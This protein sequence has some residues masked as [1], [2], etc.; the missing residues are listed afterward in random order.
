MK[1]LIIA[2]VMSLGTAAF[3]QEATGTPENP[4][5]S[6][7]SS[8]QMNGPST[9]IEAQEVGPA[10][11][12]AAKKAVGAQTSKEEAAQTGVWKEKHAFTMEGTV[13]TKDDDDITL[14]R[15][16][17]LP[18]VKLDVRDKTKVTLDDKPAKVSDLPEGAKVR[19]KFQLEGD[20]S[21]A[22]ELKAT[23]PKPKK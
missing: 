15:K 5:P 2:A 8:R 1:K 18:E 22:L 10:I 20:D 4:A 17:T 12:D 6:A 21:V 23:S 7:P 3:A 16:D 19:A 13:K 9:G 11:G 14:A